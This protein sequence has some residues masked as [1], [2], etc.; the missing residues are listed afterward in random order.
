L[1]R[2]LHPVCWNFNH[3]Q[4]GKWIRDSVQE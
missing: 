3:I 4:G 2:R 1:K